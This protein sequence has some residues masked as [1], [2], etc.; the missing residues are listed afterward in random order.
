VRRLSIGEG[1]EVKNSMVIYCAK[2]AKGAKHSVALHA[3]P[4]HSYQDEAPC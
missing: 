3:N 4:I 2:D 1:G